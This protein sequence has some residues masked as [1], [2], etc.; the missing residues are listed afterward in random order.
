MC[1]RKPQEPSCSLLPL[2]LASGLAH[3]FFA[4]CGGLLTPSAGAHAVDLTHT[5][6]QAKTLGQVRLDL[7]AGRMRDSLT[8]LFQ[9]VA[10]LTLQFDGVSMPAFA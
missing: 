3:F 8:S 1:S 4:L 6:L 10:H 9:P 7:V 2:R 5:D